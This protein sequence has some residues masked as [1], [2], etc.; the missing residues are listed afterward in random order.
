MTFKARLPKSFYREVVTTVAYLTNRCP[1]FAI[2]FKPPQELWQGKLA[3]YEE[4]KVF[5]YIAH[6]HIR[7]DKMDA[8]ALKC[9]LTSCP[10]GVKGDKLLNLESSRQRCFISGDVTFEILESSD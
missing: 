6:A 3:S 9:I 8:T 1:S 10:V 4:L 7:Q 5:G 2:N